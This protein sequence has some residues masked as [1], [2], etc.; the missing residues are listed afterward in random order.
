MK[1]I[2]SIFRILPLIVFTAA[3]VSCQNKLLSDGGCGGGI[4]PN[5]TDVTVR[6]NWTAG[7]NI[8]TVYGMRIN[9]FSLDGGVDYGR[10]DVP[11]YGGV[12]KLPFETQWL[13]YAYNYV[14]NNVQF[15]NEADKDIIEGT[16][17][18]LV[19]ATAAELVRATYSRAYPNEPTI[20]QI[21]GDL[22]VGI[23]Q[24]YTVQRTADPQ[25]IDVYP[26]DVVDTY[27]FEIRNIEGAE[28]ISATRGAM[29]GMS[30]SYFLATGA[31][32]TTPATVLFDATTNPTQ[33]TITGQFRTFGSI[34]PTNDFTV[35]ILFPS[36]TNGIMQKTWN[37]VVPEFLGNRTYR[38]ILDGTGIVVPDEGGPLTGQWDVDV[39]DW[40]NVTVPL[41]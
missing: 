25:Y 10:D 18:P 6:I 5:L 13:T 26:Q 40:N 24:S 29:S 20:N 16:S 21:V 9:L 38:I 17:A 14:G 33:G 8:P 2:K 36:S 3:G 39:K 1:N 32:S 23:N 19:R 35:E 11:C 22:Y 15:R 31:L 30:A 7:Q 28:F 37:G 12:V 27:I 41:Q 34:Q 4:D